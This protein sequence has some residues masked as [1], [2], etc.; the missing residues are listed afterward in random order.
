MSRGPQGT[1]EPDPF[2]HQAY[3]GA[4]ELLILEQWWH[5]SLMPAVIP[6]RF[7]GLAA[8]YYALLDTGS[9]FSFMPPDIAASLGLDPDAGPQQAFSTRFGLLQGAVHSHPIRIFATRG[10]D[11][12][13]APTWIVCSDWPGPTILGWMGFLQAIA[14]GCNPGL[15]PEDEARF[16]FAPL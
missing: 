9:Q 1:G 11:L 7:H 6:C 8:K 2:L 4:C 13:I 15:R 14:F 3:V 12:E 10:D 16:C 5:G